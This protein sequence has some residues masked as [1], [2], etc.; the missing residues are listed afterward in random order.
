VLAGVVAALLA[1][2]AASVL[3]GRVVIRDFAN[4]IRSH[5]AGTDRTYSPFTLVA[6][7]LNGAESAEVTDVSCAAAG[8]CAAVGIGAS[9]ASGLFLVEERSTHWASA[10]PIVVP[11]KGSYD[12]SGSSAQVSCWSPGNCLVIGDVHVQPTHAKYESNIDRAFTMTETDGTW[13]TAKLILPSTSAPAFS[14]LNC[15]SAGSCATGWGS[16]NVAYVADE[17]RGIWQSPIAITTRGSN[18]LVALSCT[19]DG[20]CLAGAYSPGVVIGLRDGVWSRPARIQPALNGSVQTVAASCS[21]GSACQLVGDVADS[22]GSQQPLGDDSSLSIADLN[23]KVEKP[24]MLPINTRAGRLRGSLVSGVACWRSGG[25]EAVGQALGV[26]GPPVGFTI[27]L[28]HGEWQAPDFLHIGQTGSD[29]Y[30]IGCSEEGLC[31]AVAFA[32]DSSN[33]GLFGHDGLNLFDMH[34]AHQPV[35][36]N[37]TSFSCGGNA[38]VLGGYLSLTATSEEQDDQAALAN[39][40][41]GNWKAL[42]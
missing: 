9:N 20:M 12:Q 28:G 33:I 21:G 29:I 30:S 3:V 6:T 16:S 18:G 17:S 40:V 4:G 37:D 23:G 27:R 39:L 41:S 7:D 35:T 25:C 19:S 5:L 8:N 10:V 26:T 42:G 32:Q 31:T 14:A 36:F 15:W 13:G 11:L 1:V 2:G 22:G 24:V 34:I 38:C